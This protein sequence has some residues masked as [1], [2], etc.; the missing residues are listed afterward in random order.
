MPSSATITTF[1]T[2]TANSKARASQVN[3]NFSI[4]RGHLL[5]IDPNT[6]TATDMTYD[7]GSDEHRW[8]N[9]YTKYIDLKSSTSTSTL[10]ILGDTS[11]TLGAFLFDIEGLEVAR[12]SKELH[13]YNTATNTAYHAFYIN[14][15]AS[16]AFFINRHEHYVHTSTGYYDYMINGSTICSQKLTSFTQNILTSTGYYD[17]LI[18]GS[19]VTSLK[20]GGFTSLKLATARGI[21]ITAA[22]G[23]IAQRSG[24][25]TSTL[26]ATT[27]ATNIAGTT[28]TISTIGY[29][30]LVSFNAKNLNVT[31]SSN[32]GK[33]ILVTT[34]IYRNG[35]FLTTAGEFYWN[36]VQGA[37]TASK[38]FAVPTGSIFYDSP[39]VGTFNYSLAYL[40]T[41]AGAV[42]TTATVIYSSCNISAREL[43]S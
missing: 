17:Y 29:P 2:F 6:I 13:S 35:S 33:S 26:N 19:T 20:S 15:T 37:T 3:N 39:G 27:V 38:Q 31:D 11:N 12:H 41:I 25:D 32:N 14:N 36:A 42:T 16:A 8:N 9:V 28:I 18:N 4:F 5:P 24:F 23:D 30:V 21:T 7:L 40:L 10:T 34:Y 43:Y 1:Y 22:A